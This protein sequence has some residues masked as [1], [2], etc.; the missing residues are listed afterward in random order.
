MLQLQAGG[1]QWVRGLVWRGEGFGWTQTALK[2]RAETL[3]PPQSAVKQKLCESEER[4]ARTSLERHKGQPNHHYCWRSQSTLPAYHLD[5]LSLSSATRPLTISLLKQVLTRDCPHQRAP[6]AGD[7]LTNSWPP[8][9]KFT[10]EAHA[11]VAELKASYPQRQSHGRGAASSEFSRLLGRFPDLTRSTFSTADTKHGVEHHI[12]TTGPP[13][14]ACTSIPP[15]AQA[16][17]CLM[18]SVLRGVTFLFIYLDEILV[19][20]EH[21]S[22]L[23]ILFDRLSQHSLI[24]N[25]T[26][27][28]FG[29]PFIDFLGTTSP[30][31]G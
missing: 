7:F 20:S 11:T 26:K 2:G 1:A 27:F 22:H 15:N 31:M 16:F 19:T 24:M 28:Q 29:L 14:H 12:P 25:P 17:Q 18:D 5:L 30:R 9:P 6:T 23:W 21:L 4:K 13:V 10:S 3:G 8:C